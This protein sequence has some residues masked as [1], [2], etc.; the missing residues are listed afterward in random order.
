MTRENAYYDEQYVADILRWARPNMTP[1][2]FNTYV[3]KDINAGYLREVG[4]A[5]LEYFKGKNNA[6]P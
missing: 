5:R 2:E 1:D 4:V 6:R 3:E